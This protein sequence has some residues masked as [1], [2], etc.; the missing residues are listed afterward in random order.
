MNIDKVWDWEG[1]DLTAAKVEDIY[2]T[3]LGTD[4]FCAVDICLPK[5]DFS[6]E[7][8]DFNIDTESDIF[9]KQISVTNDE[10]T[11]SDN[12]GTFDIVAEKVKSL[13]QS[14]YEHGR[15][16]GAE[17]T[18][19][20]T[21]LIEAALTNSVHFCLNKDKSTWEA[22]AIKFGAIN[23]RTEQEKI[24]TDTWVSH[25]QGANLQAQYAQN[26]FKLVSDFEVYCGTKFNNDVLMPAQL[27]SVVAQTDLTG[28]Q[29]ANTVAQ[30]DL[31]S[32]QK[33]NTVAQTGLVTAQKA[34]VIQ[35]LIGLKYT[36]ASIYPAQL[37]QT[38]AQTANISS[39]TSLQDAQKSQVMYT[40]A[41]MMPAQHLNTL[42]QTTILDEQL[43]G[44]KFTHSQMM[45]AQ[46]DLTIKQAALYTQQITSY[47]RDSELKAAKVFADA[48]V[49]MKTIDEG[50]L[51]PPS[52]QAASIDGVLR[53][54]KL[55]NNI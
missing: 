45:P 5:P 21:A 34:N 14:E 27:Q 43:V 35:E 44:L 49:V 30:T 31:I 36:H 51:P 53:S 1:C 12:T 24:K 17:Y 13:L 46:K 11:N 19:T 16:S 10:L 28:A 7:E 15:I 55:N 39:Q 4:T 32:A 3:A 22:L 23:A 42:A 47:Q 26:K 52:F 41:S 6:G 8:F 9:K 25:L 2:T 40:T 37:S 54:I 50:T 18:K 29:E 48:W 33:D 38:N 20:F